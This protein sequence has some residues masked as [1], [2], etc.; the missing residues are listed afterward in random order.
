LT[1][2]RAGRKM[3]RAMSRR[4]SAV[5]GSGTPGMR[6]WRGY[7]ARALVALAWLIALA[8]AFALPSS[9]SG[10]DPAA[11]APTSGAGAGAV[12]GPARLSEVAPLPAL[13]KAGARD[14]GD[15][16]EPSL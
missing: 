6:A 10:A 15:A 3:R 13:R 4:V 11:P 9:R 7:R 8:I 14:T 16:V 12:S 2:L 5:L 1:V